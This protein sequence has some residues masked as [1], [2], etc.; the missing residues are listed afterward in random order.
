MSSAET[1]EGSVDPPSKKRKLNDTSASAAMA[2]NGVASSSA[3]R[4]DIDEGL[5]SRQLYV[6]GHEAMRR[7]ANSDVL[8]SGLGGLGVEI[9]KN[10]IL[11]GVKSVTLHDDQLV[12]ISDL[13]SQ[14]FLSEEEIGK[15][16]AEACFK[17]L[18]ELNSYVPTRAHTGALDEDFIKNFSVVV[19]TASSRNEQLR[20][21]EITHANNIAL[22]IA[23]TR[24][25]FSQVFCDF[26]DSFTVVDTTGEPAVSAMVADISNDK[27]GVVTCIDDTRHGLE[28]GDY[29]TFSELEGITE[30]NGCEPRPI[31]VLGPYT[32]S[33]GDTTNFSKYQRGGIVTQVKMPKK[34]HFK[35]LK[36][37]LKDPEYLIAD[38]AKFDYPPQLHLAFTTLH[39]FI[40]KHGR[41]PKPWSNDDAA[42]FVSIAKTNSASSGDTIN[43]D[44]LETFAK[45]SAGDL[46]PMNAVIGGIVAQEVMK[47]CSGKFHPI[48]QWLYFDAIETLPTD[49]SEITEELAKPQGSRYDG[50]IAVFGKDF[51][52]KIA[53]QNYFVVG[54]GAIGCELLK[55]FAMMGLG[56]DGGSIIVTDMDLIEKSNLNRQF[57]FRPHDVQKPKSVTAAMAIKKMNPEVNVIA[58]EN[59][60]GPE[61]ENIYDDT[62][63]EALDGVANALDNV[64]ARIYMDRRCVYYRKP[65]LESGT[66][67]TKGNTQVVVPFLTESYSSS[68]DP[69]EKS[70]PICTL[71]NFPNAIEHTLQWARDTFEG[72]FKHSAEKASQYLK[73]P[74]FMEQTL[75]LPGVQP[76][77]TLESLKA[78]L[79]DGRPKN[80]EDCVAWARNYWQEQYSNQISQLLFNF[81][82]DQLTSTGQLFWSGPKRCPQPLTFDINNP[83]HVDYVVAAA[84]LKAQVYGLPTNRDREYI[85]DVISK[86]VVPEFIPKSGVKIAVTDSQMS[87]NGNNVDVDRIM[88]IKK[89]LPSR[90]ELSGLNLQ[91]LEF[92]KDDDS[93]FHMDFIVAASNLRAI[94]Y[95]IP[96][97]DRHKSKL[98]AGKIIPAI[99]TT[100]SVV[101]GLVCLELYKL[102][103]SHKSLEPFKN[104]FVNL[105]LPFFG[106][107]EPIAAP[108]KEFGGNKWTLWDRFE[109]QGE[110]TLAEFLQYFQEKHNLEITM[111]SQGVCM[112]YSFFMQKSKAQERLGLT[113]AEVV[114]RVSKKKIEPHVKALVFELCCNDPD[115]E[116]V[117]VPYVKYNL[118]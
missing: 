43:E 102:I 8:I 99:A 78:A 57:L 91:P 74:E 118:G 109:I 103:R 3:G 14:F 18:S 105:A 37:S 47:A 11:G 65:L 26:G 76:L 112:L 81:P 2:N 110:M 56:T 66:L 20:I 22:I 73:D 6:L 12:A 96:P 9:A 97:A 49:K 106:F 44:L 46:C 24:G 40:E 28:D 93:N 52:K 100:T 55:N 84:N 21:S 7:M 50:Q 1:V 108:E 94:N 68:Q 111:L 82:P 64:D 83:L 29:V 42:D 41:V 31:K 79:V 51:Q 89:E 70:I 34:L 77:E 113:M 80:F 5:Y 116:D 104:G 101:A 75:K 92:E 54:A 45:V 17:K 4:S 117:E 69:P 16:R 35:S 63:F 72:L 88:Q 71:K 27:E 19:L 87:I 67:G 32:F 95:K 60:V 59:R 30:L 62:F 10:V 90:E 53:A 39:L 38:F 61:T 98:I 48:V 85:V 114:K 33:I 13:S 115:G 23:D 107:S 36:E 25:V 58:H 86:V 15:N